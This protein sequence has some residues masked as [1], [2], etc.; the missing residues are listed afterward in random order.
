MTS[1]RGGV[2]VE[3]GRRHRN[4][5]SLPVAALHTAPTGAV[6]PSVL[7]NMRSL[8]DEAFDGDFTDDDWHHS[9]GGVHVWV[10]ESDRVIGH[11][12]LVE[13]SLVCGGEAL[14]VG[15]S[16]PPMASAVITEWARTALG[17]PTTRASVGWIRRFVR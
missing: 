8:L 11:A 12:S 7:S 10:T 14:R 1:Q 3:P 16:T 17:R 13:R 15:S 4:L 9:R 6:P 5:E 2:E